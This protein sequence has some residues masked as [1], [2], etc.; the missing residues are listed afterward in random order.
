VSGEDVLRGCL[1][2]DYSALTIVGEAFS[3]SFA[4]Q[5]TEASSKATVFAGEEDAKNAFRGTVRGMGS[6]AAEDCFRKQVETLN[7]VEVGHA[8]VDELSPTRPRGIDEAQGWQIF[9]TFTLSEGSPASNAFLELL[10]LRRGGIL[11][12]LQTTDTARPI[13]RGLRAKLV[14]ALARRMTR[15]RRE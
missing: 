2:I 8:D 3:K 15:L 7:M 11:V 10:L 4:A 1:G 5:H 13:D 12:A 14:R 6:G 9:V